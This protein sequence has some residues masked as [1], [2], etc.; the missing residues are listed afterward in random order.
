M[1]QNKEE[2][3]K[4]KRK[5]KKRKYRENK[6]RRRLIAYEEAPKMPECVSKY[7]CKAVVKKPVE[8]TN[9]RK[10]NCAHSI[11]TSFRDPDVIFYF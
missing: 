4:Q 5:E 7:E 8:C 1:N 3:A 6:K 10:T 11:P 2:R 9:T